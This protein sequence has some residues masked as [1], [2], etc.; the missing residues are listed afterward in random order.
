ML[1][2]GQ[3]EHRGGGGM[4]SMSLRNLKEHPVDSSSSLG[5]G[6]GYGYGDGDG[7][8]NGDGDGNGDG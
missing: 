6:Y 3:K 8:G 7:N 2:S 4:E 5:N 1:R